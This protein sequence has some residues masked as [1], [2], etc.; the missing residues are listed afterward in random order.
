MWKLKLLVS[1]IFF[2]AIAMLGMVINSDN[3][4][5][6]SPSL[7]GY[8]FPP[9]SL[10]IWLFVTLL[11]GGISG[12]LVSLLSNLKRHGQLTLLSRKLKHCEKELA[13]LRTSA[14]RD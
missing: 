8:S 4:D 10:G 11:M 14:L 7:F 12:Y 5:V 3:T 2:L 13:Q 1:V 6:V 9:A